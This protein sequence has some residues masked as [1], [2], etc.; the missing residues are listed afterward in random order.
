MLN[1]RGVLQEDI[2]LS[3]SEMNALSQ[4]MGITV[5]QL[6]E[7][8]WHLK[9]SN[10][11]GVITKEKKNTISNWMIKHGQNKPKGKELTLLCNELHLSRVQI[12]HIASKILDPKQVITEESRQMVKRWLEEHQFARPSKNQLDEI[13]RIAMLSRQQI[14]DMI[15]YLRSQH[16]KERE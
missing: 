11:S 5:R 2:H 7:I 4:E 15:R 13:Q 1:D 10:T 16:K 8:I 6:Y 9:D 14:H 12:Q 3:E